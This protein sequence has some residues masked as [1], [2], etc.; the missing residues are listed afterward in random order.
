VVV[1]HLTTTGTPSHPTPS[2]P[3]ESGG[4]LGTVTKQLVHALYFVTAPYAVAGINLTKLFLNNGLSYKY[5]LS[6]Y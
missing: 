5:P 3:I 1:T 4:H 6:E 2:R